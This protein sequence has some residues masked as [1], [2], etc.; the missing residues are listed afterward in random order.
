V[1]YS[2]PICSVFLV[3]CSPPTLLYPTLLLFNKTLCALIIYTCSSPLFCRSR[4]TGQYP[5]AVL[6]CWA[7]CHTVLHVF[8]CSNLLFV[9]HRSARASLLWSAVCGIQ[10]STPC[11]L[12]CYA[13]RHTV[14]HVFLCSNLQCVPHSSTCVSLF[15]SAVCGI[16]LSI[17]VFCSG[18]LCATQFCPCFSL[19]IF[20][21][22]RTVLHVNSALSSVLYATQFYTCYSALIC[23]LWHTAEYPWCELETNG[24]GGEGIEISISWYLAKSCH[25]CN[26]VTRIN[27]T[28]L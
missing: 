24:E 10:L 26:N 8:I 3:S 28:L 23:C 2:V 5:S 19:L 17:L 22:C 1:L 6:L 7:M 16:Q 18:T 9:P 4:Y 21:L 25:D 27:P 20:C 11:V 13:M 14:L 12:P 15:W